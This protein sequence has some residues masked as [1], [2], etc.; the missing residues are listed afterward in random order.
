MRRG[1]LLLLTV[2][3]PATPAT[4][5]LLEADHLTT[6]AFAGL[7]RARTAVIVPGGILEQ[8]GPY[9]PAASDTYQAR[10]LADALARHIAAR[11]GGWT[12]LLLP[13][14]PLGQGGANDIVR[15]WTYP[16]SVT[17]RS[18][19]LRAVYMD[20]ADALGEHGFTYVF[21]VHVH[22][23]PMHNQMLDQASAYFSETWG[24]TMVHLMGL[25]TVVERADAALAQ[26]PEAARAA[27]GFTVHAGLSESSRVL[28]VAPSLVE[29]GL[30]SA[31]P[32]TA[33]D[34]PDLERL[35]RTDAWKGYWG[36]PA[37]SSVAL[38][39]ALLEGTAAE[40]AAVADAVLDGRPFAR[41]PFYVESLMD[42]A[43]VAISRDTE[44]RERQQA[45]RQRRWLAAQGI[46]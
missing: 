19:T 3:V 10:W 39:A 33:T 42:P 41:D 23:A 24:G 17:I 46:D 36:A 28:F 31:P 6:V 27:D 45:A 15:A 32:L 25:K 13:M 7:D 2:L 34:F 21:L 1:V 4:A 12:A 43:D 8:H 26:L 5:Q 29:P 14:I 38:G 11:P 20:L 9:L 16:G 18:E 44:S 30:F 37:G 35:G 40:I 22:G